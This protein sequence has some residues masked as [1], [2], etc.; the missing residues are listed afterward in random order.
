MKL[1]SQQSTLRN[2]REIAE[3]AGVRSCVADV[4]NQV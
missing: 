1:W 2:V 3:A 4:G